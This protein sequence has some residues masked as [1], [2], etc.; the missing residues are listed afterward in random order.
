MRD[1]VAMKQVLADA[2]QQGVVEHSGPL[3]QV[4]R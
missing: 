4:G 3:D 2:S 1:T